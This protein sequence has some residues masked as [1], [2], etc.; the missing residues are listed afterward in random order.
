[1]QYDYCA[2]YLELFED[3][4]KKARAIAAK[5]VD[6]PVD[7]WRNAF[8]AIVAQLDEIE[9]KG[10]KVVDGE[11]RDQQQGDLAATE[12]G[13]EFTVDAKGVNLT[14]QNLDDGAGE[15]L[16]DGRRAAVQPQPV[17]A[18]GRRAVRVDQAERDAGREAAG[19]AG[20]SWRSRCRTSWRSG[21]CWSR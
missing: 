14:W 2:A 7:R 8:A 20:R 21:T 4:P 11:D 15:L 16:P 17:R 5:Y 6:H 13:F 12:P 1:M 3:E 18:A 9:G 10:G 19:R